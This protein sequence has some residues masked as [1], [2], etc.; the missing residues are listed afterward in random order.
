MAKAPKYTNR[1][2]S[3]CCNIEEQELFKK[4]REKVLYRT[5]S[6]P[7]TLGKEYKKWKFLNG[8]IYN[9]I[10]KKHRDEVQKKYVNKN[11]EKTALYK[12]QYRIKNYK[13]HKII[14][15]KW[16]ENNPDKVKIMFAKNFNNAKNSFSK[17]YI[18]RLII[19]HF[20]ECSIKNKALILTDKNSDSIDLEFIYITKKFIAIIKRFLEEKNKEKIKKLKKNM[21]VTIIETETLKEKISEDITNMKDLSD[22]LLNALKDYNK[23]IITKAQLSTYIYA[24]NATFK[25]IFAKFHMEQALIEQ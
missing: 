7:V 13:K 14:S 3:I 22:L 18:R 17:S 10:N 9:Y 21:K 12:K 23:G 1:H 4:L 20:R 16:R 5:E 11:K 24:G 8:K 25:A 19:K 6:I 15:K 2:T